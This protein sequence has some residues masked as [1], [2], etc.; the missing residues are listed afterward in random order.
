AKDAYKSFLADSASASRAEPVPLHDICVEVFSGASAGGMCAAIASVMVQ[1]PFTH[2]RTG[3]ETGTSNTFYETWVNRIDIRKLLATLHLAD[4]KPLR[5]LLDCTVIDSI[6]D[7]ALTPQP[8]IPRP[9]ISSGLTLFLTLSNVRGVS[10][11]LYNDPA[12]TVE[13]FVSYYGDRLRF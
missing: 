5:S 6:A 7:Y 9:F 13:E 1:H 12:P 8:T 11:K 10:Y 4:N 3:E 2:V